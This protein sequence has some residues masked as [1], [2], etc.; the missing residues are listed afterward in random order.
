MADLIWI[1]FALPRSDWYQEPAQRQDELEG[2]WDLVRTETLS[3]GATTEGRFHIR[4]QSDYSTVEVWHFP[5]AEAA[6]DHWARLTSAG[7]GRW[8]QSSNCMGANLDE[9]S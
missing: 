3:R 5:D 4:G 9:A 6:F 8:V 1:H 2:V 7:Y